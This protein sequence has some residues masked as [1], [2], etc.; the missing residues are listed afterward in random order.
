MNIAVCEDI[1]ADADAICDYLSEH[2][3]KNGYMGE[4]HRFTSGEALLDAFSPGLFD[5]VF[6]D[7]YMGGITGVETARK[8]RETDPGFALVYVTS[9]DNHAREAYTLR[10]CA[11]VSKTIGPKE[12]ELA[13][14]QCRAVFLKNAR[15]IEVTSNRQA[16]KIPLA[17]I[18]YAEVYNR[19]VLFHTDA[20]VMTAAMKLDD[21][22]REVGKP[23]LRCH[24]SYLINM[25]HIDKL[26]EQDIIMQNGDLVPMRQRGKTEI[27]GAYS[28]FLTNRLFEVV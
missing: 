10:A 17:K 19:Y 11:Y 6:L 22:E 9:S 15:F 4:I 7:I 25:N 8:M 14:S 21:V 2:F 12:M 23:F 26:L 1:I 13:L 27:R 3:H 20:G 18:L 28:D 5:V 16:V 24:R